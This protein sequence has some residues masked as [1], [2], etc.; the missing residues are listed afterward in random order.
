[1]T[2]FLLREVSVTHFLL[3]EESVT[4]FLLR[5][6]NRDSLLAA[7]RECDSLLA[8]EEKHDSLLAEEGKHDSLLA[9]E[10][11]WCEILKGS[12]EGGADARALQLLSVAKVDQFVS[13][14]NRT[15]T[16]QETIK[17]MFES[18]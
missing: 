16:I 15:Q 6:E 9:E 2:H 13:H 3:R 1:M 17:A 4:H 8:E 18:V 12:Y 5:E 14:L 7:G 10:E 11:L